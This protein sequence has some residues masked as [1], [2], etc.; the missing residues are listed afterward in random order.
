MTPEEQ[1]SYDGLYKKYTEEK[2]TVRQ[3]RNEI[4]IITRAIVFMAKS[5]KSIKD[6][7]PHRKT[8]K[9]ITNMLKRADAIYTHNN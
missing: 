7:T 4:A 3:L 8:K 2:K 9:W 1:K 6:L 5:C